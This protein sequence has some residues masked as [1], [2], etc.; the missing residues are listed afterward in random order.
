[1]EVLCSRRFAELAPEIV[2]RQVQQIAELPCPQVVED[3]VQVSNIT[4]Q[5]RVMHGHLEQ[6]V[7]DEAALKQ[8]PIADEAVKTQPIK[9]DETEETMPPIMEKASAGASTGIVGGLGQQPP[10]MPSPRSG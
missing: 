6:T 8:Q 3:V 7:A 1:M 4:P 5:E 10:L 2:L 9:S